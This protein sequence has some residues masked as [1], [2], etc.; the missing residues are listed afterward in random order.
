MAIAA[1]PKTPQRA[2]RPPAGVNV[3]TG[4]WW[5]LVDAA[6]VA[7]VDT[8]ETLSSVNSKLWWEAIQSKYDSLKY[9]QAWDL[10]DLLASKNIV[11]SKWVFKHKRG[12][13]GQI[14]QCKACLVS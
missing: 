7:I 5:N 12:V 6:S 10:V 14:Q 2:R 4:D 11:G 3:L 13:D 8:E 9:N 1:E